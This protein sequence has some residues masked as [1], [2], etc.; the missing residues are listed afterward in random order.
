MRGYCTNFGG[1][2]KSCADRIYAWYGVGW[3][4]GGADDYTSMLVGRFVDGKFLM[5]MKGLLWEGWEG[6]RWA[7]CHRK[8]Q[9][10]SQK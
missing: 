9:S 2:R 6:E 7:G 1:I 4:G 3:A 5:V 10:L 8:A